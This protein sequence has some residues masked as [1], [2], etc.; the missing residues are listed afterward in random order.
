MAKG[1]QTINVRTWSKTVPSYGFRPGELD[2]Y[3]LKN[4]DDLVRALGYERVAGAGRLSLGRWALFMV[5]VFALIG[6]VTTVGGP[7]FNTHGGRTTP[8]GT[9]APLDNAIGVPVTSWCF[10]VVLIGVLLI[11]ARWLRADRHRDALEIGCLVA[12]VACGALALGQLVS[13]RGVDAFGTPTLPVWAAAVLAAVLL[14]AVL[15]FSRGRRA[16]IP[17]HFR[18]TGS[19][20][21]QQAS[22]LIEQLDPA[23][24]DKLL[25]ERRRAIGRLRDRGLIDAGAAAQLEALPLGASTTIDT[26]TRP[27]S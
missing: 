4:H 18:R 26:G 12:T 8:T 25:G 16:S 7:I 10:V 6:G 21:P 9:A 3:V 1:N 11:G 15:L 13:D 14:A 19:P 24:R 22:R 23:H 5:F 27:V 2:L 17:N 20:D